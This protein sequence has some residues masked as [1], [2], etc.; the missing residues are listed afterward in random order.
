M[1]ALIALT[2]KRDL[3]KTSNLLLELLREPKNGSDSVMDI[4]DSLSE[5][6][7]NTYLCHRHKLRVNVRYYICLQSCGYIDADCC[8]TYMLLCR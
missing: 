8:V 2:T 3:R 1:Q 4:E 7:T 6:G 5:G